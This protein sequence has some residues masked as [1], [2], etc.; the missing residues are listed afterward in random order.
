MEGP[1][2]TAMPPHRPDA[3]ERARASRRV[4]GVLAGGRF[5]PG[6]GALWP[7]PQGRCPQRPPRQEVL[8]AALKLLGWSGSANATPA[9]DRQTMKADKTDPARPLKQLIWLS[10]AVVA[11]GACK[12]E[13]GPQGPPGM[14]GLQGATGPAGSSGPPGPQ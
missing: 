5:R 9:Q 2:A 6:A 13:P 7:P 4:G 8:A 3:D 14:V 12:G 11:L 1:R 10:L